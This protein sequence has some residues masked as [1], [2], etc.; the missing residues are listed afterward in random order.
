MEEKQVRNPVGSHLIVN[1]AEVISDGCQACGNGFASGPAGE[2]ALT[3]IVGPDK[4]A[5]M[6]CASCGDAI[7]GHVQADVVRQRYAWDWVIPVKGAPLGSKASGP[8]VTL[9][10]GTAST[11]TK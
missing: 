5:Y 11:A 8:T 3:A 4:S 2:R 7:M 10:N 1:R 6:F 9:T